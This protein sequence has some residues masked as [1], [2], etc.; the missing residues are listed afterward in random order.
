MSYGVAGLCI[1]GWHDANRLITPNTGTEECR[2]AKGGVEK[3]SYRDIFYNKTP[4]L[5]GR[6]DI[7]W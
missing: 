2:K 7:S 3:V 4:F 6:R 1:P 5:E